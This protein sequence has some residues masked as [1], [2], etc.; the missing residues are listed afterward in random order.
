MTRALIGL[1]F[2]IPISA[3]FSKGDESGPGSNDGQGPD[4]PGTGSSNESTPVYFP[5]DN[6]PSDYVIGEDEFENYS[7]AW[8]GGLTWLENKITIDQASF[9]GTVYFGHEGNYHT[10]T[11]TDGSTTFVAGL[12][13]DSGEDNGSSTSG[14]SL[15]PV[16]PVPAT[17]YIEVDPPEEAIAYA[18]EEHIPTGWVFVDSTTG[19]Y[20]SSEHIL[21]IGP[22]PASWVIHEYQVLS[23]LGDRIVPNQFDATISYD[24][25]SQTLS[26]HSADEQYGFRLSSWMYDEISPDDLWSFGLTGETGKDYTDFLPT[27]KFEESEEGQPRL[28]IQLYRFIL[29]DDVELQCQYSNNL[30]DWYPVTELNIL[31][32]GE[33]DADIHLFEVT[34]PI[35]EETNRPIFYRVEI[36]HNDVD[37]Y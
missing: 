1:A 35:P 34:I 36:I 12:P 15:T 20:N 17:V 30:S 10:Q 3:L 24:G 37:G 8:R 21:R 16:G 13:P 19:F 6:N 25:N 29:A 26:S 7:A 33:Y 28:K 5:A 9:A 32:L 31:D 23:M 18:I 27:F 22:L 11:N 14:T 4:T 2:L